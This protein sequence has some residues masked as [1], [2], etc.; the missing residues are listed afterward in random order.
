MVSFTL[1]Q[2]T[3]LVA[4]SG[5]APKYRVLN[6]VTA[7]TGMDTNA[8]VFKTVNQTFDH[9]AVAGENELW[10]TTYAQAVTDN[11]AFYRLSSVTRDWATVVE[12]DDDLASTLRRVRSL[13]NGL[14]KHQEAVV[15]DRTTVIEGA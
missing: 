8:F 15:I 7:A 10:P 12:M 6:E 4:Q 13:A 14:T 5:K 1:R 2:I 9:V 11:K 3:S